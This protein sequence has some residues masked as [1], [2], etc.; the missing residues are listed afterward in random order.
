LE[1]TDDAA[2]VIVGERRWAIVLGDARLE[3]PKFGSRVVDHVICDPPYSAH[4]H[5][6]VRSGSQKGNEKRD[7]TSRNAVS[8]GVE[9][10]FERL[11]RATRLMLAQQSARIAKR[12][13]MFFTDAES[14]GRWRRAI[15]DAGLEYVRT[16]AWVRLNPAPQ[17]SGDRPAAGFDAVV[18]G[19]PKG[20]KRWN[21]GGLPAVWSHAVV[22]NRGKTVRVHAT[23]KPVSLMIDLV[24][25]FT[26][27]R[28]IVIDPMCGSGSTGVAC[29][30]IGRRFIGIERDAKSAAIARERLDAAARMTTTDAAGRGQVALFG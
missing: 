9:L 21:G 3:L 14:V 20:R 18:I 7:A 10:G 26:D 23:E 19:H 17:F 16:G 24:A 12:W 6:N 27:P 5:A 29:L 13:C 2:G 25:M 30:N 4:V 11:D 28:D 22:M 1:C 15:L 8:R